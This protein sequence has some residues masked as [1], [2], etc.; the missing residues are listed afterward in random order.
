MVAAEVTPKIRETRTIAIAGLCEVSS[1][2]PPEPSTIVMAAVSSGPRTRLRLASG[3]E[4]SAE[5]APIGSSNR[6][7]ATVDRPCA[8]SIH[9]VMPYI[10]V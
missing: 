2:M 6:P 7:D 9:W 1:M 3:R 5:T 4:S 10:T 8:A